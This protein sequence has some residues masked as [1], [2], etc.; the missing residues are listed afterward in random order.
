MREKF[1]EGEYHFEAT[2]QET[3]VRR[4]KKKKTQRNR[5]LF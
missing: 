1:L 3:L 4:K 5:S 2:V